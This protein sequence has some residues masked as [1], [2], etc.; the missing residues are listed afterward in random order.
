MHKVCVIHTAQLTNV[1]CIVTNAIL[2]ES[3]NVICLGYQISNTHM[4]CDEGKGGGTR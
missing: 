4:W 2:N 1:T 3:T